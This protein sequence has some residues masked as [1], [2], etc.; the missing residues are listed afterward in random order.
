MGLGGI[1]GVLVYRGCIF[2]GAAIRI[3]LRFRRIGQC[4]SRLRFS[5]YF[6]LRYIILAFGGGN[7]F[8]HPRQLRGQDIVLQQLTGKAETQCTVTTCDRDRIGSG[9]IGGQSNIPKSCRI[10]INPFSVH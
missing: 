3:A 5:R 7:I 2:R 8:V 6:W 10:P 4:I 1:C 9:K